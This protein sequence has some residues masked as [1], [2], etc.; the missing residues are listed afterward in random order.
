MDGRDVDLVGRRA[1]DVGALAIRFA[2]ESG[3]CAAGSN[4]GAAAAVV[5]LQFHRDF[6]S[7]TAALGTAAV[8]DDVESPVSSGEATCAETQSSLHEPFGRL[9]ERRETFLLSH[10]LEQFSV[11]LGECDFEFGHGIGCF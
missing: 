2:N 1:F 4:D 10:A 8:V 3:Q 5:T 11:L 6:L 7:E 9:L